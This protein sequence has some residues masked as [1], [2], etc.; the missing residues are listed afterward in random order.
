LNVFQVTELRRDIAAALA[1]SALGSWP[2]ALEKARLL[3]RSG[4]WPG[5]VDAYLALDRGLTQD[6]N[7][8]QEVRFL[9]HWF[10]RMSY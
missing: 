5:A 8:L 2:E 3:E 10:L 4:N 9:R 1:G 6:V 7:S